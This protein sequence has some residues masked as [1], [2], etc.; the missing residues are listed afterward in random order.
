MPS[1]PWLPVVGSNM[2]VEF[3]RTYPS[4]AH[5]CVNHRPEE[6]ATATCQALRAVPPPHRAYS[7]SFADYTKRQCEYR[8]RAKTGRPPRAASSSLRHAR[9]PSRPGS[10]ASACSRCPCSWPCPSTAVRPTAALPPSRP[11]A[12]GTHLARHG[13][14]TCPLG[15]CIAHQYPVGPSIVVRSS[16]YPPT[17]MWNSP[18]REPA[19]IESCIV[20]EAA[21]VRV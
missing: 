11:A 7:A 10:C 15:G 13:S 9:A 5:C 2:S 6:A 12:A 8:R 1:P 21:T 14:R 17:P 20:H 3:S 4:T 16:Q 19:R 18:L